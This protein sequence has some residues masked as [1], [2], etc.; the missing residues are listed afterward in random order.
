MIKYN[1]YIYAQFK[2][3]KKNVFDFS[4]K[5]N[6]TIQNLVKCFL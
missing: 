5:V 6:A 2:K 4:N 3:K 1:H